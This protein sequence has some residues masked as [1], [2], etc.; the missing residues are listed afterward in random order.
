MPSKILKDTV[1]IN[2]NRFKVLGFPD[3]DVRV[4]YEVFIEIE[5]HLRREHGIPESCELTEKL[6]TIWMAG[7]NS[8][9]AENERKA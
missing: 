8:A 7:C 4:P 6:K 1:S 5:R 2:G 3:G 9:V